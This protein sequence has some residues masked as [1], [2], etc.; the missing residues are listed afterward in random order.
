MLCR[1]NCKYQDRGGGQFNDQYKL[2]K[3]QFVR[4]IFYY[5]PTPSKKVYYHRNR[6]MGNSTQSREQA[7]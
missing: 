7:F 6:M 2:F 1:V 3:M 4:D 5:N